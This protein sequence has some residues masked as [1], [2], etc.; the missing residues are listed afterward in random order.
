[1]I[2]YRIPILLYHRVVNE[3]CKTGKHKIY[4]AEKQ[5]RRQMS[6]LKDNGYRTLTFRDLL[7]DAPS[8]SQN[9]SVILTFD[10]GYEDNYTVL[11]PILKEFGFKAVIYLVTGKRTNEWA[12][13]E[14]E[15][16]LKMMTREMIHDMSNYGIEFG[17]HTRNHVDLKKTLPEKFH[18]EI[19]GCKQDV[20]A[21]TGKPCLSFAYPFGAHNEAVESAVNEAGYPFGISTIFG[22]VDW[23]SDLMKIRRIEVRPRTTLCSFRRKVSGRYH[24]KNIFNFFSGK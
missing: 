13:K 21:M 11:F 3:Q 19:A 16:D 12:V 17:G 9:P 7:P 20:E 22:P 4:V 6:F 15:P 5:F 1:M 24:E 14:G 23:R 2:M 18:D 8:S 10:D